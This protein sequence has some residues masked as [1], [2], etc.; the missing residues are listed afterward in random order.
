MQNPILHGTKYEVDAAT[1]LRAVPHIKQPSATYFDDQP[2]D[3]RLSVINGPLAGFGV[4]PF[5]PW[6][7]SCAGNAAGV[8]ELAECL[9]L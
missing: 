3:D 1:M 5:K 7:M 4:F 8:E 2:A 9:R 6:Y